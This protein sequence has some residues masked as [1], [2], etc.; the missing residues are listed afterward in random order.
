[1]QQD[2]EMARLA[3]GERRLVRT[4]EFEGAL[5]G[6]IFPQLAFGTKIFWA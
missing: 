2:D 3:A 5:H 4:G 6:G 1:M